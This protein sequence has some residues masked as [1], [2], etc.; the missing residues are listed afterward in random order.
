MTATFTPHIGSFNA[1]SF[2]KSLQVTQPLLWETGKTYN[3][4]DTVFYD[5]GKYVASTTGVSGNLPPTHTTGVQNDGTVNWIFVESIITNDSFR[6]NLYFYIANNMPWTDENTPDIPVIKDISDYTLLDNIITLQKIN[7]TDLKLGIHRYNWLTGT[8]YAQYTSQNNIHDYLLPFYVLTDDLNIYKCL[9]NNNGATSTSKPTGT[10][11][12]IINLADGY[13][14]KFLGTIQPQDSSNYLT[15]DYF[16]VEYKV[17]NDGSAQWNT[18]QNA[19]AKSIST[20]DLIAQHGTFTTPAVTIQGIGT[21][22]DG[23]ATKTLGNGIR[24]ILLSNCG[25]DYAIET[26]A[27]VTESTAVGTGA[28]AHATIAA[29]VITGITID[30]AGFGY[31][32]ATVLI[33]GDGTLATA[34]ATIAVDS[35]IQAITVTNGGTGYTFAKIFVIAGLAGAIGKAVLAPINGHGSNLV[36]ELGS[37]TIIIGVRLQTNDYFLTG[38]TSDF[39]QTGIITDLKAFDGTTATANY[40]LA[41]SHPDYDTTLTLNKIK[42]GSGY[43]LYLSNITAVVRSTGQEEFIKIGLSF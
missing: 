18:Q 3:I 22:A 1:S 10:S 6:G 34:T 12:G 26:Y 19:K 37:N 20:F 43:I 8:V 40:Y 29:G 27:I 33:Y 28:T 30:L 16:P 31:T 17:Y 11:T 4:G 32:N 9:N 14:W 38:S 24:Q 15:S 7:Y 2:I 39:R 36:A 35:S 5:N 42:K 23:F 25:Q 13:A 21:G 41:P